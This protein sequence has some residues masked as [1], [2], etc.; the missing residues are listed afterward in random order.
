MIHKR[1]NKP[2][3]EAQNNNYSPKAASLHHSGSCLAD[4]WAMKDMSQPLSLLPFHIQPAGDKKW[5]FWRE[6]YIWDVAEIRQT[7]SSWFC[8]VSNNEHVQ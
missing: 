2:D 3:T 1:V 5:M 8:R 7:Q 4:A 6:A